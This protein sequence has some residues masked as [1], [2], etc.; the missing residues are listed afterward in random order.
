M[1]ENPM[2]LTFQAQA[3]ALQGALSA[4]RACGG[5]YAR[6]LDGGVHLLAPHDHR[7]TGDSHLRGCPLPGGPELADHYGQR[8]HDVDVERI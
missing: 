6:L 4:M 8:S 7:R 1:T 5:G 3:V 2:T